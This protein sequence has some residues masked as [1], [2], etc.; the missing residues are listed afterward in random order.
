LIVGSGLSAMEAA[1]PGSKAHFGSTA[2]S[3]DILT[4]MIGFE[5]VWI[6]RLVP[7]RWRHWQRIPEDSFCREAHIGF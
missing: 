2:G 4:G 3:A 5:T 7:F 6:N 1:L